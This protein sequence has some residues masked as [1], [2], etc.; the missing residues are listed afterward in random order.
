MPMKS[1]TALKIAIVQ[2][3]RSSKEIAEELGIEPSTLSRYANGLHVPHDRR[4][5][6]AD[7]LGRQINDLWPETPVA[8]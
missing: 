5:A 1:V 3:G 6:I 2:T 4:Q 7:A 8:A